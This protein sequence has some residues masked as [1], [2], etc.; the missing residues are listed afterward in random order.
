MPN[1]FDYMLE[2]ADSS[3]DDMDD[4][5]LMNLFITKWMLQCVNLTHMFQEERW[6]SYR[7]SVGG[8]ALLAGLIALIAKCFGN[9]SSSSVSKA[10]KELKKA[11]EEAKAAGEPVPECKLPDVESIKNIGESVKKELDS[12]EATFEETLI[13]NSSSTEGS[14]S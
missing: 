9:S 10:A 2:S 1:Y 11:I 4:F 8:A 5:D 14:S 12:C 13:I 3:V 7:S 6:C